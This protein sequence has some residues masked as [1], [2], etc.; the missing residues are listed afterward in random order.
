MVARRLRLLVA[1][2]LVTAGTAAGAE[3]DL[4]L[5][6]ALTPE[7]PYVQ[8]RVHY[9]VRVFRSSRLQTGV[10]LPPEPEA[11]VVEAVGETEERR[12][13]RDGR[14]YLVEVHRFLLLPQQ[15]GTVRVPPP[16]FSGREVFARG[17][18][19]A[20]AVRPVPPGL[21]DTWWLPAL[22][23]TLTEQWS[24]ALDAELRV[25]EVLRQS[26]T[27]T[28]RGLTAAQLPELAR[29]AG[30]GWR[31]YPA[32]A[33]RTTR[34][35][36][37]EPVATRTWHR[38]WVPERAGDLEL[39][40]LSLPWWH[41]GT[42]QARRERLPRRTVA[43]RPAA[44]ADPV[45]P[46]APE[47]AAPRPGWPQIGGLGPLDAAAAA[48]GALLVVLLG[49]RWL[50]RPLAAAVVWRHRRDLRDACRKGRPEAVRDGLLRWGRAVW[51]EAPPVTL[52]EL[53]RRADDPALAGTVA[54]LERALYG[55]GSGQDGMPDC[56]ELDRR[57]RRTRNDEAGRTPAGL[58]PLNP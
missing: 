14:R 8:Q 22:D 21:G 49:T 4:F 52:Q 55:P 37:G 19:K 43:V 23:L 1:V 35:E 20:L 40:G 36:N 11:A 57:L 50:R 31:V 38:Y 51:P 27:L 33:E 26:V 3:D 7:R 47:T 18:A 25:G 42:E 15:S 12:V 30:A 2:L 44:A 5:E 16:V 45:R 41:T 10:L 28:A 56:R 6:V 54:A 53:A 9:T 46:A 13:E 48:L 29:R 34:F 39:P 58:P 32:G 24:P 17:P